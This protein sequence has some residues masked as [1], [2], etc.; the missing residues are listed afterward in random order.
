MHHDL[1]LL[2]LVVVQRIITKPL[3]VVNDLHA[4]ARTAT[5]PE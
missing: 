5:G 4:S 1:S 3:A 2:V